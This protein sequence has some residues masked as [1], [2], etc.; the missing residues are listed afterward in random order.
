MQGITTLT[1]VFS[2]YC[3]SGRWEVAVG[4]EKLSAN[5]IAATAGS[6]DKLLR[7]RNRESIMRVDS[8][9]MRLE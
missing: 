8:V 9:D 4:E 1:V 3:D 6:V 7:L 5:Y 2:K